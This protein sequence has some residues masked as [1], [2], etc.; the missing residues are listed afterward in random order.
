[1]TP[2]RDRSCH[3]RKAVGVVGRA[4]VS[5]GAVAIAALAV[6]APARAELE[7][8]ATMQPD[9]VTHPATRDLSYRLDLRT[10][11]GPERLSVELRVPRFGADGEPDRMGGSPLGP[12]NG[13]SV[14]GAAQLGESAALTPVLACGYGYEPR[15]DI[16]SVTLPPFSSGA[17][18]ARYHTGGFP[19]WPDTD[20]RLSFIVRQAGPPGT[21]PREQGE[22]VQP[23]RP[24]V[25]ASTTAPRVTLFT[26]PTSS[27]IPGLRDQRSIPAGRGIKV[28]GRVE[29]P[30][31]GTV[32]LRYRGPS[33]NSPSRR[34]AR[35]RV[36]QRPGRFRGRFRYRGW[37]PKPGNYQVEAVYRPSQRRALGGFACPRGFTVTGSR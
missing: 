32:E 33:G 1:M 29:P 14:E 26:S 37:R 6:A 19:P 24:R 7:M 35:V 28:Y 21:I 9:P 8:R 36:D 18:I 20:Y 34:L 5:L 31:P 4:A 3:L 16:V 2:D 13:I 15:T 30:G 23:P 10:G 27:P 17:L 11:V 12:V 22:L 25:A